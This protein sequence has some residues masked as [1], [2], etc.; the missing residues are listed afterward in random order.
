MTTLFLTLVLAAPTAES[1]SVAPAVGHQAIFALIVGVNTS[2]D[3]DLAP[4]H[5]ADDDA[6]QYQALFRLV[7]ARTYLMTTLDENTRR[8]HPQAAAEAVAPTGAELDRTI[9]QVAKDVQRARDQGIDTVFYFVFAG[10]GNVRDGEGY[11]SL[12]DDRLTGQGLERRVV[13]PV[14]ANVVHLIVDACYSSYLVYGRGPGGER[15]PVK[16][17]SDSPALLADPRVGLLL[18]T[19]S[20]RESHEWEGFQGG[21]FSHEVRSGLMGAADLDGDGRVSYREIGAFVE[22]ANAAIPNERFRPDVLARPPARG[23]DLLDLRAALDRRLEI[24]RSA[25]D[26]YVLED[27]LGVRWLDFH[28]PKDQPLKLLRPAGGTL[29]L[30][31]EDSHE[32]V[33]VP[34]A[35]EVVALSGLV[36]QPSHATA[37]GAANDAF[38]L[39]FSLPFD[40]KAVAYYELAPGVAADVAAPSRFTW[41]N[42]LGLGL[43]A[44]GAGLLAGGIVVS[45]QGS[46][47][48][49]GVNAMTSQQQV[50]NINGQI[51]NDNRNAAILYGTAGAALVAGALLLLWPHA[52]P[53]PAPDQA[54][55]GAMA[56]GF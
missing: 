43:V 6:A 53:A 52:A 44:V 3:P 2:V 20:A 49:S 29:Y 8:L 46:E 10:H 45:V 9:A 47:A 51:G 24:D 5:Y 34:P 15:R 19:S 30:R 26:H 12:A 16:G 40:R 31:D 4:L 7:G 48:A 50:S 38:D 28:S 23:G 56:I 33:V 39:L 22:R 35:P 13:A 27:L 54:Q 36:S 42:G 17:F 1:A 11:L 21:V 55:P 41:R 14:P 18:S 25:G 32:E 37:R